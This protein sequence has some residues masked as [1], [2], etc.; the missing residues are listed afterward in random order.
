[1]QNGFGRSKLELR[2][3]RKRPRLPPEEASSGGFGVVLRA[4]PDG[5]NDT[6]RCARRRRFSGGGPGGAEPPREDATRDS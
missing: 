2:G 5:D 3:T 4:E 1:M 6:A